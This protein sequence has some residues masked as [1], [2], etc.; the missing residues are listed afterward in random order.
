M[1]EPRGEALGH[2]GLRA[3]ARVELGQHAR[4]RPALAQHREHAR[5]RLLHQPARELL[6]HALGHERVG[7]AARDH[8]AHE[9]Q[10]LR[11][12]REAEARGEARHAQDAHRVLG[13]RLAHVAQDPGLAGRAAPPWGSTSAPS[14]PR[15]IALIVRSRRRRSSSSVTSGAAWNAKPL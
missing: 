11:R 7:L 8:R 3:K 14:S 15:A 6:P 5:G 13:E 2:L 4:E 1:V 9:R 12:D 10:R